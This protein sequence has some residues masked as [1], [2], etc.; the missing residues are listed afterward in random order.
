MIDTKLENKILSY[1]RDGSEIELMSYVLNV[2]IDTIL[3]TVRNYKEQSKYKNSYTIEFKTMIAE[4]D[5]NGIS[6]TSIKNE[7]DIHESTIRKFCT[8]YGV[9]KKEKETE[10]ES[11]EVYTYYSNGLLL[12]S[13]PKCSSKKL[14]VIIEYFGE[15]KYCMNCSSQF[16]QVGDTIHILNW[17]YID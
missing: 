14:N 13:C 12:D 2:D 7:L 11:D 10:S 3:Q 1:Y 6:R 8:K 16:K 9:A 17:E 5:M 4:R 15:E